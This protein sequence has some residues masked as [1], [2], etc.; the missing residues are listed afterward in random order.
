MSD[1]SPN[2]IVS[3]IQTKEIKLPDE[4]SFQIT[5]HLW[6]MT[7]FKL[8]VKDIR[9]KMYEVNSQYVEGGVK[10]AFY[11][12]VN[13]R[14]V[15]KYR[16]SSLCNAWELR[17]LTEETIVSNNGVIFIPEMNMLLGTEDEV[18]KATHPLQHYNGQTIKADVDDTHYCTYELIDNEGALPQ[19]WFMLS[20][21]IKTVKAKVNPTKPSG[22]YVT[23]NN[24]VTEGERKIK[25]KTEFYPMLD[26]LANLTTREATGF[27]AYM[28][29]SRVE[30]MTYGEPHKVAERRH[31]VQLTELK[32]DKEMQA[33]QLEEI[34]R[35]HEL[36]LLELDKQQKEIEHHSKL[37][38][39][40]K[41]EYYEDK[42]HIRRESTEMWKFI[43]TVISTVLLFTTLFKA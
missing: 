39:L 26:V 24:D 8:Y 23:S 2:P 29:H 12:W 40:Q 36:R 14:S 5:L 38:S 27:L 1:A 34:K 35:E 33:I 11:K 32:Q 4:P 43:P 20:G 6:N 28:F 42:S 30:A 13:I 21:D 22:V 18:R 19:I 3:T 16:N 25:D 9:G 31:Q 7:T 15:K 10:A 41:K 17:T 37:Q